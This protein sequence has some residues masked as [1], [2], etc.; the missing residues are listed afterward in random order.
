MLPSIDFARIRTLRSSQNLGFEELCCQL[1]E[2][3]YPNAGHVFRRK[4]PGADQGVECYVQL[5]HGGEIGWQAKWFIEKFGASQID[6]ID[7]SLDSALEAHPRLHT[8]IVCLPIN[9]KDPKLGRSLSELQR[10]EQ[11][12]T[13]RISAAKASGRKLSIELWGE[14][15][16]A[17]R[18][19]RDSPLYRG[20]L[21]YWFGKKILD[22]EWFKAQFDVTLSNLGGRYTPESHVTL[23][24]ER[25]LAAVARDSEFLNDFA[26]WYDRVAGW[27]LG[28]IAAL[29]KAALAE[30]LAELT[31]AIT[32]LASSLA[33]VKYLPGKP[34]PIDLWVLQA[35]AVKD[36]LDRA[37]KGMPDLPRDVRRDVIDALYRLYE[38]VQEIATQLRQPPWSFLNSK[39]LIVKG[40]AG[41]GKSHLLGDF[42][43]KQIE[44]SKPAIL[45]LGQT[46]VDGDPWPQILSQL[47]VTGMSAAN[48]LGALDAAAQASGC[49]AVVA[50]DA[51]NE[52]HGLQIWPERLAGFLKTFEPYNHV[53]VVLTVRST[54]AEYFPISKIP[55][56]V[57]RGFSGRAGEA[58]KV[59]L[60][61][62]GIQR[63]SAPNLA[64]E[65][66]NPLFLRTC[67]DFLEAQ[68]LRE[69]PRGI[70]GI[71]SLF[72]FYVGA[73]ARV[74]E[75]KL[76]LDRTR[77]IPL[78]ALNAF[79]DACAQASNQ[80]LSKGEAIAL[81]DTFHSANREDSSLF[82]AMLSEGMLTL[83]ATRSQV[84][85]PDE[86]VRFTF[87]R[88]SDHLTAQ[89]L[90]DRY[91]DRADPKAS[92]SASPLQRYVTSEGGPEVSGIAEAFAVQLPE[93]CGVEILDVAPRD[94]FFGPD[95]KAAFID[96]LLWRDPRWFTAATLGWV[97]QLET[98]GD[99]SVLDVLIRVSAIP[100]NRYN[101]HELHRR[102]STTAMPERD[103]TWSIM[104]AK[105][106]L[107][108][109]GAVKSLID[110]V[111]DAPSDSIEPE[112]AELVA[113][114]LT[115]FLTTSNRAV[116][117]LS[118]KALALLLSHRLALASSLLVRFKD[119]DEPY[120]TERLLAACYGAAL[121]GADEVNLAGLAL[122]I[123][124]QY[125]AEGVPPVH[126]LSRD[127]A[128]GTL[129]YAHHVGRLPREVDLSLCRGPF[130]TLWPTEPKVSQAIAEQRGA[131]GGYIADEIFSSCS[132]H[133]D[134]GRY[135]IE[136][137]VASWT[138]L[139][140]T[141]V[142]LT[143]RQVYDAWWT[144]F[145]GTAS[146]A[147]KKALRALDNAAT[148]HGQIERNAWDD[149]SHEEALKVRDK[150]EL[151]L[152]SA[153]DRFR[154]LLNPVELGEYDVR[155]REFVR[156]APRMGLDGVSP[157][158]FS[159]DAAREWVSCRAHELGWSA[160]LFDDFET[161]GPITRDRMGSHRVERV[162]KKYQWIAVHELLAR[163]SDHF[164][165]EHR[166]GDGALSAYAGNTLEL[167]AV[168]DIDPS[169]LVRRTMEVQW[170]NAPRT[171]WTPAT[172]TLERAPVETSLAW[173]RSNSGIVSGPECVTVENPKD[174]RRWLVLDGVSRWET[175]GGKKQMHRES[176]TRTRCLLVKKENVSKLCRELTH[177]N[178]ADSSTMPS[179]G[180][181]DVYLGEHGWR[182]VI[183]GG[184]TLRKHFRG[185]I[186]APCM[187]I[188]SEL[189]AEANTGDNS[190]EKNMSVHL[191]STWLKDV[192][193]LRLKGG[194]S[195]EYVDSDGLTLFFDPSCFEA[196]RGAALVDQ[197]KFLDAVRAEGLEPVWVLA[198][199]KNVYGG[200]GLSSG[201]GGR[202]LHTNVYRFV[203]GDLSG[204]SE[205]SF[206]EPSQ[207][208]LN[209]LAGI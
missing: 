65:F 121:Q 118:T 171:W 190:I 10:F 14:S 17:A 84:G 115:W 178:R 20:R 146:A 51:L 8:Y 16:I 158:T 91:L 148:S 80:V 168:R 156:T 90:L 88:F 58:A 185:G 187:G 152:N 37:F 165:M 46:L 173:L 162:G 81:F 5:R 21:L 32:L 179:E 149:L 54:Y 77:D 100:E 164:A 71:T 144:V 110:W 92:F 160:A 145:T 85:P 113:I 200:N 112:L 102:L 132:D 111:W 180:R 38:V 13:G 134:F 154:D 68:S 191:P 182:S 44:Q 170:T 166:Q 189:L 1:A 177:R 175:E 61:G 62:R 167:V 4:G 25:A 3:E 199:E 127:Y 105:D 69:F 161:H 202:M 135:V 22:K 126:I 209:A 98:E 11:W 203:D 133:G 192:L 95:I 59:Y 151:A 106:D 63:F 176:W 74:I 39:Q 66:E 195:V 207:D 114:T 28:A 6:Q 201:W 7:Q 193:G 64:R 117:D 124:A 48:F 34:L 196:G 139:P 82:A 150:A 86:T 169:L 109:D 79:T 138:A 40:P 24:I 45:I 96:S 204:V 130:N 31:G 49:R 129:E 140:L 29:K 101:A 53:A 15:Q 50:I 35:T 208:Q 27:R 42:V 41:T 163:V 9:L 83:E 206:I 128:L 186:T 188:V 12:R 103:A 18:L 157:T 137:A 57:H 52:R 122:T 155:A 136:P 142:G 89:R 183:E 33:T 26:S 76:L 99:A 75:R 198:G 104:L 131:P 93:I 120:V 67:C 141:A 181:V 23:P 184:E 36:V 43:A 72:E 97:A 56:V 87:E 123:W 107:S 119:M 153:E 19:T 60:D 205:S 159:V 116:R 108:D 78:R 30:H 197:D 94:D 47:D 147:Q 172:L 174:G 2:L 55:Q 70:R 143:T 125:Y 194:K 73:V